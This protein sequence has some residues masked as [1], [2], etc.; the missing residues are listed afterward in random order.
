[1]KCLK[2]KILLILL[3]LSVIL[4]GCSHTVSKPQF[5]DEEAGKFKDF[6][7]DELVEENTEKDDSQEV[8]S[9][10]KEFNLIAK[11]WEFEPREI[12]VNEGDKVK[13]N[14]KSIDVSHGIAI[15]EFEINQKINKGEEVS[16]EFIADKKGEFTFSCN[17]F[18]GSGHRDM[19][20]KLIIK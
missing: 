16:I 10:V 12:I 5:N 14:I 1:M 13:I 3:V 20:G 2:N 17:V 18:C 19:N 6:V 4:S 11:Q 15:P 9:E 7:V 8:A